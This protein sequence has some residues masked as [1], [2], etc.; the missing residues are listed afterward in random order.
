MIKLFTLFLFSYFTFEI[1]RN[2]SYVDLLLDEYQYLILTMTNKFEKKPTNYPNI[3]ISRE[4]FS[5][6]NL[7]LQ[8]SKWKQTFFLLF[9]KYRK[10]VDEQRRGRNRSDYRFETCLVKMVNSGQTGSSQERKMVENLW[11]YNM[12]RKNSYGCLC[13]LILKFIWF[14]FGCLFRN[15]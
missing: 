6:L 4:M 7:I 8:A 12:L 11:L 15:L 5:L 13:W 9:L 3:V 2:S 14:F 1:L 10:V